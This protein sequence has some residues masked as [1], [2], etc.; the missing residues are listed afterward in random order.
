LTLGL[1][2]AGLT[3]ATAVVVSVVLSLRP[4]GAGELETASG[5]ETSGQPPAPPRA[6]V[7]GVELTPGGMT[8]TE[9]ESGD[10]RA[11]L[12]DSTN[13]PL[14]D[15]EITWRSTND[16]VATV[17]AGLGVAGVVQAVKAGTARIIATSEGMADTATVTVTAGRASVA[18]VVVQVQA[19]TL[20]PGETVPIVAVTQDASNNNLGGRRTDWQV[21]PAGIVRVAS[22]QLTAEKDGTAQIVAVSEGVS[23][24]PI[25]IVVSTPAIASV[26]ILGAP[27]SLVQGASATL[28]V[29]VRDARDRVVSNPR[30]TWTS[31]DDARAS[32]SPAGVVSARSPGT[33]RITA[34]L[35]PVSGTASLRIVAPPRIA[36]ARVA[37]SR[38]V[39]TLEVG[40]THSLSATPQ[41]A[42]GRPLTDR[43]VT[44]ESSNPAVAT[45]RLDGT[46]E[47]R[48]PGRVTITA[49]AEDQTQRFDLEVTAPP[50]P[51][52]AE[53]TA[54]IP[55][56]TTPPTPGVTA[57]SLGLGAEV[58]C[59]ILSDGSA[60][61]WGAGAPAASS[62][63]GFQQVVSGA[64]HACGLAGNGAVSCWGANS[65]GQLGSGQASRDPVARAVA[66]TTDQRF[67]SIVA[68][69][70]HTCGIASDGSAWCWGENN[71][72]QLGNNSTRDAPAPVAVERGL[73]FLAL[74]AGEKHTCGVASDR[75]VFCWGDGFAN[76][77]GIG[78]TEQ[79]RTPDEARMREAA[80]AIAG[81]RNSTCAVGAEGN[82]Y[83]WGSGAAFGST[84]RRLETDQ[85]FTQLAV[86]D[87]FA[88]GLTQAGAAWCWGRG[89]RGQ[90]GDGEGRD[91]RTPVRVATTEQLASIAAGNA[92][93]CAVTRAGP[94]LCWG[95]NARGQV[96]TAGADPV[97]RP[98]PVQIRR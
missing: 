51:V 45:V 21:Q 32:I 31:N 43:T 72:A 54:P 67:K 66:V 28:G 92:H 57:A 19:D 82:T 41:D 78:I 91:S 47:A 65:S 77:L 49:R 4:S 83:C 70:S 17:R 26:R 85:R 18:K 16:G 86:G 14:G 30:V 87:E 81:G 58:S 79:R 2:L 64:G 55:P 89:S 59:A 5:A 3:L 93:A 44:W 23:S 25:R 68:G 11:F 27:D 48:A 9:G 74:A 20:A 69:A 95:Q 98:V 36:V 22:G 13:V 52:T 6:T 1:G 88:C 12:F 94:A 90:L 71:D 24:A 50:P 46:I 33:A 35:G 15:R 76:Q 40:R 42:G 63:S 38:Q 37:I 97:L 29:E 80:T 10:L 75:K 60:T 62:T 34:Q 96:G 8:I 84:P 39:G 61:C 53:E 7:A 56:P 73:T